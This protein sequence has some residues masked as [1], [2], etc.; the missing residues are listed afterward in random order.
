MINVFRA[1]ALSACLAAFVL[2][3]S[4]TAETETPSGPPAIAVSVSGL[5][6]GTD[7][8]IALAGPESFAATVDEDVTFDAPAAG[9]YVFAVPVVTVGGANY[10][11]KINRVTLEYDG[12][13]ASKVAVEYATRHPRLTV[14]IETATGS[15]SADF[16]LVPGS[17]YNMGKNGWMYCGPAHDVEIGDFYMAATECTQRMF[18]AATG[19]NPSGF[20]GDD[21][22]ADT[23]AWDAAG[24][25]GGFCDKLNAAASGYGFR[26]PCESEWEYAAR[27]G[28]ATDVYWGDGD[29]KKYAWVAENSESKT[30]P[31]G[32]KTP[33]AYGLHD[34]YGNVWEWCADYWHDGYAGAPVTAYPWITDPNTYNDRVFRGGN[35][36]AAPVKAWNR[37]GYNDANNGGGFRV[38]F[39]P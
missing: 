31:C 14:A 3:C 1:L 10:Y 15:A 23:V 2:S 37:N 24:G 32:T 21:L 13:A 12:A 28:A 18:K 25:T 34:M 30:H 27:G 16:V 22:P 20:V 4:P 5:P 9:T 38:V 33:N 39:T 7:A 8:G 6:A 11:P 29:A 19:S 36:N 35:W 17:I 26:L